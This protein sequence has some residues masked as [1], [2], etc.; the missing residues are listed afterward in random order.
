[1]PKQFLERIHKLSTSTILNKMGLHSRLPRSMVF[2]PREVGG[3]GLCNLIYE[4]G[5]QQI[6][7]LL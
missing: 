5:T 4:Q 3:V 6:L 7:I 1:M 2:A